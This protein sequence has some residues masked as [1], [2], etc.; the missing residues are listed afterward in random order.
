MLVGAI[1]G[2]RTTPAVWDSAITPEG[3]QLHHYVSYRTVSEKRQLRLYN[4]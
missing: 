3:R 2:R 1:L 4:D